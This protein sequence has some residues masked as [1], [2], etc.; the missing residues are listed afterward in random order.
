M[1]DWWKADWWI[2]GGSSTKRLDVWPQQYG[3]VG[4]DGGGDIRKRVQWWKVD[5]GLVEG[6]QQKGW[7]SSSWDDRKPQLRSVKGF[8]LLKCIFHKCVFPRCIFQK[9]IFRKWIFWKVGC[10]KVERL[11]V[12]GRP[13]L[14]S[15]KCIFG[16]FFF[17]NVFFKASVFSKVYLSKVE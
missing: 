7:M 10:Q 16:S 4:V 13:W 1:G 17:R 9:C 3:A 12:D 5:V 15:V 6:L 8:F 14:R 11:S 2:G